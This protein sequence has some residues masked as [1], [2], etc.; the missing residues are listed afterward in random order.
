VPWSV[1]QV[2]SG[3]AATVY[4]YVHVGVCDR[5]DGLEAARRDLFSYAVVDAYA[6]NFERAGFADEVAEIRERHRAGDREGALAAVSD[7]FVDAI[8]V[9]GD[10]DHVRNTVEAYVAAGVEVPV[11]MP[12]PWGRDRMAVTDRTLRAAIGT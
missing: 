2:R 10:D 9:M 8:D 3:G 1:E 6:R 7:R 4:A 5:A 11:V 12:L